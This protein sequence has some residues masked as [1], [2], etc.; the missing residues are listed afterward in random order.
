M[1]PLANFGRWLLG[2]R[3]MARRN[4]MALV[5][6]HMDPQG[7]DRRNPSISGWDRT[8]LADAVSLAH[9]KDERLRELWRTRSA[10]CHALRE[11]VAGRS[12]LQHP[13]S[14]SVGGHSRDRSRESGESQAIS[15]SLE[16]VKK[17]LTHLALA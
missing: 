11:Q 16:Y 7:E 8:G 15:T 13:D 4:G 9:D 14:G 5:E 1:G 3:W 6:S 17:L 12:D 2:G 10:H